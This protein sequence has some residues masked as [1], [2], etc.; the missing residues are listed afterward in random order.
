M[1]NHK[2]APVMRISISIFLNI[3]IFNY[4]YFIRTEE[5]EKVGLKINTS[6]TRIMSTRRRGRR[7]TCT[8]GRQNRESNPIYKYLRQLMSFGKE[9]LQL[10]IATSISNAWKAYWAHKQ[11]FKGK[12]S[13]RNKMKLLNSVVVPVLTYGSQAWTLPI[14]SKKKLE[15]T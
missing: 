6:K 15:T 3:I 1:F 4:L 8:Q 2:F 11:I 7:G 13:T 9:M 5:S 12:I 14:K 10:E